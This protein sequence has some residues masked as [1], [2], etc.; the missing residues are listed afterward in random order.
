MAPGLKRELLGGK[1]VQPETEEEPLPGSAWRLE[2]D[3]AL[4][5]YRLAGSLA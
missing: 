2:L 1:R 3:L 4:A 5:G